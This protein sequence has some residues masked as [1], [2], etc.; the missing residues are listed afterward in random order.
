MIYFVTCRGS[1]LVKIGHTAREL[2]VR[3]AEFQRYC[4]FDVVLLAAVEGN[5]ALEK[6]FHTFFF[7]SHARDE[8][9]HLDDHVRRHIECIATGNFD[10]AALPEIGT[11]AWALARR[12]AA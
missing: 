9:F 1:D 5:R 11:A 10:M 3:M 8:W 4:P 2:H 6:R 12:Q 7:D